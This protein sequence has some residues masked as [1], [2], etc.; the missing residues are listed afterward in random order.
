MHLQDHLFNLLLFLLDF[1]INLLLRFLISN[2]I[3]DSYTK[4]IQDE[5]VFNRV[6]QGI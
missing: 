2:Q 3:T 1:T 5:K 6:L 4:P